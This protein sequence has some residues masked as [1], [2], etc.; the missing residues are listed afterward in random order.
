MKTSI[1]ILISVFLF[2]AGIN[3]VHAQSNCPITVS[4]NTTISA[5]SSTTLNV[6]GSN[7]CTSI[8]YSWS[9]SSSLSNPNISTTVAT[10]TATTI[11]CVTAWCGSCYDTACVTVTVMPTGVLEN[12][13]LN[14]IHLYP[15]PFSESTTLHI[16]DAQLIPS[17]LKIYD[18]LG[19]EVKSY[20]I[21]NAEMKISRDNLS[22]GLY[23]YRLL[24]KGQIV[25][26]G[27][28]MIE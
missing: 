23:Y 10:P 12:N 22:A 5:G 6:Y 4:G 19:K 24:Q 18:L 13:I 11:Y 17:E 7:F 27:K 25:G 21:Q 26:I 2:V 16:D 3:F 20:R 1:Q 8:S 15:N 28:L 9:P 14:L